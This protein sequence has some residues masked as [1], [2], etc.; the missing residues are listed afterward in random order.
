MEGTQTSTRKSTKKRGKKFDPD[1]V[2]FLERFGKALT[3]ADTDTL[4]KLWAA[5]SFVIG[6]SMAQAVNEKSEVAEFFSGAKEMYNERGISDTRP[7]I[8]KLD[9]VT[10]R[11]ALCEVRWPYLDDKGEEKGAE[12]STYV[13]FKNPNDELEIRAALMH[14][15]TA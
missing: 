7:E 14:G 10:P 4:T 5:P 8:Q 15:E 9:W 12:T 11:L 3:S 2:D 13:L 6:D 1:V